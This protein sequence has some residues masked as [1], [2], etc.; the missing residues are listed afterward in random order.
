MTTQS[1]VGLLTTGVQSFNETTGLFTGRTLTAGSG[2]SISNGTGVSGNPTISAGTTVATSYVTNIGTATPS[3]NSLNLIGSGSV[4]ISGGGNT[5][6]V[7]L[8]GLTNHAVLVGA[9]S[10]LITKISATANTG[11]VLQNNSG[12][13]PSYSTAT[14]PSTTTINQLLYSSAANTVSGLA[15]ANSGTLV[16][17]SSGVPSIQSLTNGQII[18]GITG[19]TP[20]SLTS[21][22]IA[23]TNCW[24][25]NLGMSIGSNNLTIAGADGTAL[26]STNPGFVVM[27]SNVTNGALVQ[28]TFTSNQV[29]TGSDL[30]NNVFGTTAGTAWD[31]NMP[32]YFGVIATST[33]SSPVWWIG[34]IPFVSIGPSAGNIGT[35]SSSVADSEGSIFLWTSATVANYVGMYTGC[36]GSILA[37]K[38]SGDAWTLVNADTSGVGQF[39]EGD[40]AFPLAQNGAATGTYFYANGG[41]APIFTTNSYTYSISKEGLVTLTIYCTGDGGTDGAG[42][43]NAQIA[44]PYRPYVFPTANNGCLGCFAITEAGTGA[45]TVSA[46]PQDTGAP[47]AFQ[48]YNNGNGTLITNANFSNGSRYVQAKLVYTCRYTP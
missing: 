22:M 1:P 29:L 43:V 26:S 39:V 11:A 48:F 10:D 14:Y 8:T 33:D 2:I 36:V 46:I 32:L 34:R 40:F 12:A 15:T 5:A 25:W 44:M 31:N 24:V 38:S 19:Q 17:S 6:T 16:T 13:D 41:T 21:W 42:A 23:G 28:Y 3:S 18:T 35:P 4:S 27:K 9:G 20:K 7:A 37:T 30:T 45:I 47:N